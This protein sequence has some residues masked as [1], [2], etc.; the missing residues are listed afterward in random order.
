MRLIL[1]ALALGAAAMGADNSRNMEACQAKLSAT[2]C[3]YAL[4]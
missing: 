3:A 2:A 1:I 4:R